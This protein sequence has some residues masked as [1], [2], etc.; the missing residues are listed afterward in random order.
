MAD[1]MTGRLALGLT[2]RA[3]MAQPSTLDEAAREVEVVFSTGARAWNY[4]PG[5]GMAWEE[6]DMSPNAIRMGRLTSGDAPVLDSHQ[7]AEAENVLG[8]VVAARLEG[9]VGIA[10]LRFSEA[11]DVRSTWQKVKDGTLR[12]VSVGYRIHAYEKMKAEDGR[13]LIRATDWEPYEISVVPIPADAG[14]TVRAD[15][16]AECAAAAPICAAPAASKEQDMTEQVTTAAPEAPAAAHIDVQAERAAAIQAERARIGSI[17]GALRRASHLLK[18]EDAAAIRAEAVEAGY[19]ADRVREAIFERLEAAQPVIAQGQTVRMGASGDDPAAIIDAMATAIAVRAMPAV[20]ARANSERFREFA[21]LRP[22]DMLMELAAARGE[23][24]SPRMRTQM[25]ERAFHTTSDFPMLLENAGNKML[26]AGFDQ[27][28]PS[29]RRFFARRSFNDFKAHS[30][31]TAGDFPAL[32][33]LGEG[34]EIKTGTISEKR[35]RITAK[36]YSR[37]VAVT[38]QMLVNDDLG[39]FTDFGT[40]IGRRVADQENALAYELMGQNSGD[41]PTLAEG[42]ARVFTT[43]RSNKAS[44][45][46]AISEAALDAGF[47]AIMGHKS[48]DGLTLNLQPRFLV[49]GAAYRGAALRFTRGGNRVVAE[50]GANVPLYDTME[51]ISD[52]NISGNRWYMFADPAAAPIYAYGYVGGQ[53]APSIRVQ[54]Y[55]P[56]R[57][58]ILVEVVH[59]FAVGAIGWRG[60]WFNPGA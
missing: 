30:F 26:E 29:Y 14:A 16:L 59:D 32:Q 56:G 34:G 17:D 47:A 51:P 8:R 37:G 12:T 53:E 46:A 23:R 38:R 43:G 10:R 52:A 22:S 4:I 54:Q 3:A 24:V 40:M 6:L 33:E 19:S 9:G 57:D 55:V 42:N 11:D 18:P 44:A 5:E 41:G 7:G 60:G 15:T 50:Q 45:G 2:A 58:G 1:G 36:T 31:L 21:G 27:A 28:E 13:A 25:V 48:L 35:E 20:A 39:A 49:T